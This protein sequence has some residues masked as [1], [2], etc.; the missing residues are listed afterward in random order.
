M[1]DNTVQITVQLGNDTMKTRYQLAAALR[2]LAL[3]VEGQ[4]IDY[5]PIM[6]TNGN[7]VGEML[8]DPQFCE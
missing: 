7:K 1:E 6:D 5:Y 8:V 3:Q 2:K 4:G